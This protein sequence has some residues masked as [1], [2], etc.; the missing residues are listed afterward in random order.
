MAQDLYYI[1]VS[2]SLTLVN[3]NGNTNNWIN[4]CNLFESN[5]SSYGG[6][7]FVFF[8]V[9]ADGHV[10]RNEPGYIIIIIII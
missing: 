8:G 4:E 2:Q 9:G 7:D 6:L 1:A 5:L 3:E 10:A